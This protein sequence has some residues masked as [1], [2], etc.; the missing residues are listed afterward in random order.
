MSFVHPPI[1]RF[2]AF[3]LLTAAIGLPLSLTVS[4]RHANVLPAAGH[5]TLTADGTIPLP[6]P[7]PVKQV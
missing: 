4:S 3:L 5:P 1:S 2:A 7:K 6:P